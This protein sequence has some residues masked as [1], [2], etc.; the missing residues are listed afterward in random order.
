[1]KKFL[2]LFC[3]ISSLFIAKAQP[4][5]N[6]WID[7]LQ[8]HYKIEVSQDGIYRIPFSTLNNSIP[9]FSSL[10]Q[11]TLVLYHNGEKVPLYVSTTNTTLG[12]NDYIEFYGKRNTGHIDSLLYRSADDQIN[13][14][15]SLFTNT[16]VY[17]L[18][19]N[20]LP[21]NPRL[22]DTPNVL[23]NLPP[24][25]D[26]FMYLSQVN[27]PN[28]MYY[29]GKYYS[30]G[31]TETYKS[32]Y[33][34][35]EGYTDNAYFSYIFNNPTPAL[36]TQG[37]ST[38]IFRTIYANNSAYE[39]HEVSILINNQ[40]A[41]PAG[42]LTQNAT[43][44]QLNHVE[45]AVPLSLLNSGNN[46]VQYIDNGNGISSQKNVVGAL[47]L[48]YPRYFDFGNASQFYFQIDASNSSKYLE[49]NNFDAQGTQPLLYDLT[50][51]LVYRSVQPPGTL[52][53][54]FKIDP[55]LQ[56]REMF[57]RA[58]NSGG[59]NTVNS[60]T[61]I[62]FVDYSM[63]T[64]QGEYFIITNSA[65]FDDGTASHTNWVE[66]YRKYRDNN[67]NPVSGKYT[68]ARIVDVEV[69]YDQ[70]GYGIRKSPLA[71][72]NFINYMSKDAGIAIKLKYAFLIGKGREA[73]D[74]RGGGNAYTQCL[75]PTFGYPGSDNLL[76]ASRTSDTTCAAVGRL[77]VA[78][79]TQIRDY[80]NKIKTYEDSQDV[81]VCNQD[82]PS[83]DW[84]KQILHFS[85]GT[86]GTEQFLFRYY[87]ENY[88]Y[89]AIDTFWGANVTTFSKTTNDPISVTQSEAIKN[90]INEGVSW[91]TFF[92]H[93][94]TGA[95]DFSIDEPEN[96]TNYGKYPILLSNG[97][98]SGFI[99][100]ANPGY[101]E[102]FVLQPDKG[103]IAFMA[104]SSLSVSS[105]LNNFSD[106]LYR[107][108]CVRTYNQTLG[109]AIQNT[110]SVMFQNPIDDYT[111]EVAYEM[112]LHGDPGLK[113]NQYPKPDYA[114]DASSV[115]T[116][117]ST[118]A[119]GIDSFDVNIIVT[120][121]GK[122]IKDSFAVNL[123]RT[124]FDASGN[125]AYYY[126][127][128]NMPAPYYKDTIAFKIPVNISTLGYGQ[129]LF[130]P[131]ID[132]GSEIDE[133][134][135]CN[136]SLTA[137]FSTYIQN[138]DI[139]PIYPYEFAI[140]PKRGVTLKASTVNP[141]A[142]LRSYR[143]QLDTSEL[144]TSP[145]AETVVTQIG[146]VVH[147]TTDTSFYDTP[148]YKDSTV[149]YWRVKKDSVGAL[150]HYSSFI[151]LRN[152]YP[153]WNQS[154]YFQYKKD[155]YQNV[156]L[157]TDRVFKF[158]NSLN[159]IH[160]RTGK[161]NAVGGNV[162]YATLG[163]DYNNYNEYRFRMGGCGY[164]GGGLTFAVID[165]LSGKPWTSFNFNGDNFGDQFGNVHC[166]NKGNQHGFDFT[167]TGTNG[168]FS[169]PWSAVI[170]NFIDAI[171]DG[172]FVLMYSVNN[173][174]YTSWDSTLV[175]ALGKLGFVSQQFTS[176]A[177]NGQL[178]YFTQKGNINY[179]PFYANSSGSLS[180]IDTSFTFFGKWY[181]GEFISPK[182]GPAVE[183]RSVH[184]VK[185]TLEGSG[186]KND[187]DSL[188]IIGVRVNGTDTVLM[189]TGAENNLFYGGGPV[190]DPIEYPY[191][192]L[193]LH[194]FDD[195]L[196]TPTQLYYW[197]VLYKKPPEAAINPAAHLVF[198]DQ[199]NEGGN[200]HLEIALENVSEVN[201]DSILTKYTIR[202]ASLNVYNSYIR[203]DK[204]DSF[205]TMIMVLDRN[206]NGSNYSGTNKL[207]I[208]ANP[209]NDQIEQYHFNN[210]AELD[211]SS[212]GDKIN[213]LLDVTF[214][215]QHIL[216][217]D[218]VSAKPNIMIMLKDEN[219]YLALDTSSLIDVYIKYP[220]AAEP[221]KMVYDN[222]VMKFYPAD[223][224]AL[225]QG[226]KAQVELKP[227][228][229][230]DGTYELLVKDRDRSGNNSA[231]NDATYQGTNPATFF[232]Y[233]IS[234]EVITK[235][236]VTNVLNYPNPFTTSTKFVFTITGSE[237]PDFMKIQI[238]TIKGTVVK[239]IF[240]DEL[241]PLHIGRNITEYAWDG[242]DQYGDLLANGIYFYHVSTRLDDKQMD[243]M[244]MSYDKFFKK[245]F[246]KMAIIR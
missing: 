157:D 21:N 126:Y 82:I 174:P 69:L 127:T 177:I 44:F 67:D 220:G 118:V 243:Q 238:M 231:T 140:V 226:N 72:R 176:G 227:V 168:L 222:V 245:G 190:I 198:T 71:I 119:P 185:Q 186:L 154:H 63:V 65:L 89:K 155:E 3:F 77:A 201:M 206:I 230:I 204:L 76:A 70:F 242:R 64:N 158:P 39:Q 19:T 104:T 41:Y 221:T 108:T 10:N 123:K 28:G 215:N 246:G 9:N 96:Y 171:P 75:V 98:F 124:I 152:E 199:V 197:R 8:R 91:I 34:V 164:A 5:G 143:L 110:L 61:P 142:P 11:N 223:A 83:K 237:V 20:N 42:S 102:R 224:A 160:V 212:I 105:G 132:A 137:P 1:M 43:G 217:G 38:A 121:L 93:S 150:W 35:G 216:N 31:A 49:I 181:Q 60:L 229:T 33:D 68:Q 189:T 145:I 16:S 182:I 116:T 58:D 161:A 192:R 163:W 207:I 214:D 232:D 14:T 165:S 85:G 45:T 53:L 13:P 141:F 80:L 196:R 99:H 173:P 149:Y 205:S 115:Y 79:G 46:S 178:V 183:W 26:Y 240:K 52:P 139:I 107:S 48:E 87:V 54:K 84:Q 47:S 188:D 194:T 151:Y 213:P 40:K 103:V 179:N 122:A 236:M 51:G 112:T 210:I 134:G 170:N 162:D 233:K 135:E 117:P 73:R 114:I 146:G 203:H 209:D 148:Q 32:I 208:E 128:K 100:D 130:E 86:T 30:V 169:I 36:Y 6:E 131:T 23:S 120:N 193:R 37:P 218:I 235:P 92:G 225:A 55:S 109:K 22:R 95:F 106:Q 12:T 88:R 2:L 27:Y 136:N 234:F 66:E 50:N 15:Y 219:K 239:E 180:I 97:C 187:K 200:L 74:Y 159:Q 195:S 101:S 62:N 191:L 125:P 24:K 147:W 94:A 138:D 244:G 29:A 144:F 133:M 7:P 57:L 59:Y 172:S 4:F 56:K 153:G 18:T 184:W 129:N 175:A 228:F 78:N 113:P 17:Y 81:Y 211:F 166:S 111:A 90:K 167:T 156:D 241:G 25:E 202:D